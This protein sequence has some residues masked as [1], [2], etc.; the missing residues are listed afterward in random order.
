MSFV[1]IEL[2]KKTIAVCVVNEA[3]GGRRRVPRVQSYER[4]PSGPRAR[5]E[6]NPWHPSPN[7]FRCAVWTLTDSS[8]AQSGQVFPA[9]ASRNCHLSHPHRASV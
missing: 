8:F 5:V 4:V 1:S 3:A 7:S 6:D 2:H 9:G